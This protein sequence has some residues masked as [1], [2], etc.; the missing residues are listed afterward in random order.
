MMQRTFIG[1]MTTNLV[2]D[3]DLLN[4]AHE[5]SGMKTK[6]DTVNAALREFIERRR[7]EE[8][9]SLFGTIECGDAYDYK[10]LRK[11]K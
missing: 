8:I 1:D 11:R 6:K 3:D 9:I 4:L 5:L 7:Q 10:E 2:L